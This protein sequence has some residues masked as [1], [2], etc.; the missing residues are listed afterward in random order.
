M[1]LK[2]LVEISPALGAFLIFLGYF[3]L[4]YYY[5][6][7]GIPIYEYLDFS[8]IILAFLNDLNVIL[9][10]T[11]ITLVQMIIGMSIIIALDS[12]AGQSSSNNQSKDQDK[13]EGLVP[14][15]DSWLESQPRTALVVIFLITLCFTVLFLIFKHL[16]LLYFAFGA[17]I[18]LFMYFIDRFLGIKDEK[19]VLQLSTVVISISFTFCLALYDIHQTDTGS[20][21]IG[22]ITS[23]GAVITTNEDL[24]YLGKTNHFYMFYD[25][26]KNQA[27]AVS[28][29]EV[30]KVYQCP[31]DSA[32]HVNCKP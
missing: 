28:T 10:F 8:E 2:R 29:A 18:Q 4:S 9:F 20:Q 16:I 3:K 26:Q 11:A 7:W 17:F 21:G 19:V 30:V 13:T 24:T 5:S 14:E 12:S 6:H 25:E 31:S 27:F 15:I 1:N 23:Q 32:D 22:L